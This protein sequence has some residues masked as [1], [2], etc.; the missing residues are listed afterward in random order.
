M[1]KA[2]AKESSGKIA[3]GRYLLV[4]F[5][6]AWMFILGILVGRRQAPVYFDTLA[7][8]K[9]L[10]ALRDTALKKEREAVEKAIRGEGRKPPLDFYEALK[11]DE[12]DTAVQTQAA[13]A[14]TTGMHTRAHAAESLQPPHKP[15]SA[16]MAKQATIK[17]K[18][19]GGKRPSMTP[20]AAATTDNLTIQVASLKDA[21][22]AGQMV[23]LLK[24]EG[25][26]AYL[27]RIVIP[28][29]GLWF[30]VQV[31]SY[32]GREQAAADMDRLT[33]DHQKPILVER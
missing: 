24:E 20:V 10:I 23:A 33:R 7:L 18:T 2:K 14:S 3:W 30:R 6:A 5:I 19:K 1:T 12:P 28:D 25:Y 8:Q 29:Q 26:P 11:K 17:D 22:A 9:E 21:T 15:R 27:S 4:F 16:I 31:G 13:E 32:K